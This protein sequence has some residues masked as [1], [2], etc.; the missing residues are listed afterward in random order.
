MTLGGNKNTEER[1]YFSGLRNSQFIE[2]SQHQSN[3]FVGH[4]L[5][6]NF[7]DIFVAFD[8]K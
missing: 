8:E 4:A 2:L 5:G 7:P 1:I 6:E 3:T